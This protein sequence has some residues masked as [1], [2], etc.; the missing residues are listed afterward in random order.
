MALRKYIVLACVLPAML[1]F[2]FGCADEAAAPNTNED[3]AP[4]LAPTN[5]QAVVINGGDIQISWNPSSQPNVRGYNVYRVDNAT[6]TVDRLNA[7]PLEVTSVVDGDARFG[8]EYD[9]RVT[10]VSTRNTESAF[11]SVTIRNR[12]APSDRE[13]DN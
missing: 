9:Y 5:V 4:V 6:D 11:S 1:S 7:S 8:H 3:E 2:A 10:A 12:E 13:G